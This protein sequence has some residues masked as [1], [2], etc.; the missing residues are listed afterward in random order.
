MTIKVFWDEVAFVACIRE[1]DIMTQGPTIGEA[2]RRLGDQWDVE[3]AVAQDSGVSL[4]GPCPDE[5]W[6]EYP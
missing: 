5:V 4:P 3:N 2:L 1:H 6:G